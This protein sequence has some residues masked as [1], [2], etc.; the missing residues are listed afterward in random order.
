MFE[1]ANGRD[2]ATEQQSKVRHICDTTYLRSL[3]PFS[4]I[5]NVLVDFP[6]VLIILEALGQ[7]L[8]TTKKFSARTMDVFIYS[9]AVSLEPDPNVRKQIRRRDIV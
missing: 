6:A 2:S 9:F 1:Y 7:I 3:P 8:V 5:L 4:L